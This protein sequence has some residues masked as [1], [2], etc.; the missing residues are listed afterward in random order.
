MFV[1]EIV[2]SGLDLFPPRTNFKSFKD[3]VSLKRVK[4]EFQT[5]ITS[6]AQRIMAVNDQN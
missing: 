3:L 2:L 4:N 5:N 6:I 1:N